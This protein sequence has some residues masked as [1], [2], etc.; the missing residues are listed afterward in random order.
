MEEPV[1]ELAA[2][3]V[4]PLEQL[5]DF[6][7]VSVP[8]PGWRC[9]V[10]TVGRVMLQLL[11]IQHKLEEPLN[12][13]GDTFEELREGSI[14]QVNLEASEA[15]QTML[16]ATKPK[17]LTHKKYWDREAFGEFTSDLY[18]GHTVF[19]LAYRPNMYRRIRPLEA[20]RPRVA[21]D[22]PSSTEDDEIKTRRREDSEEDE[23]TPAPKRQAASRGLRP[24]G[25]KGPHKEQVVARPVGKVVASGKGWIKID[26]D[27]NDDW[28]V[29]S[30]NCIGLAMFK[31]G[32]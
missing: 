9:R 16:V 17:Q 25:N 30:R 13:N 5:Q 3:M 10:L 14:R 6:R 31:R 28:V 29:V 2:L 11:A 21:I 26:L 23:D 12:L 4:R 22:I 15:F 1:K 20:R 18:D 8:G 24:R 19:D 32:L 7:L 27:N